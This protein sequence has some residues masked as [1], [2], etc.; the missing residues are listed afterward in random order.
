[1]EFSFLLVFVY[2]VSNVKSELTLNLDSLLK[3][4][5]LAHVDVVEYSSKR[6]DVGLPPFR[7][8]NGTF[9]PCR[10]VPVPVPIFCGTKVFR[11]VPVPWVERKLNRKTLKTK[12]FLRA[13]PIYYVGVLGVWWQAAWFQVPIQRS[14][15]FTITLIPPLTPKGVTPGPIFEL[16]LP[17]VLDYTPCGSVKIF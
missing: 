14:R 11:S 8:R 7:A 9:V 3:G 15:N 4:F 17:I 1:M 13:M 10:S 5:E 2:T 12:N 6:V 16:D